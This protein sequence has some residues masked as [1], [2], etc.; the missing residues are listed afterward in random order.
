[1]DELKK[2]QIRTIVFASVCVVLGLL[3]C[4]IPLQTLSVIETIICFVLLIYGVICILAYCLANTDLKDA[5][6]LI[7]GCI[8]TALGLLLIFIGA[9]FVILLGVFVVLIGAIYI[10]SSI[11]DKKKNDS[12]W[13]IGLVIGIVLAVLGAVVAILCNTNLAKNIVM[14]IF[15]VTLVLTGLVRIVYLFLLHK[16]LHSII[17]SKQEESD[18][19]EKEKTEVSEVVEVEKTTEKTEDSES[20]E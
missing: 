5:W 4:I 1:M 11:D 16:E 2:E 8:S 6:L 15:G 19:S 18:E 10:K 20:G 7:R 17:P 14:V 13:W 3:F 9:L 12:T